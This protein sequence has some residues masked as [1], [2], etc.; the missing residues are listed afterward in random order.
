MIYRLKSGHVP[1]GVYLKRFGHRDDDK[2]WSCGGTVALTRE[3]LFRH[4]SRWKAQQMTLWKTE[5]QT[6]GWKAGNC[7]HVQISELFTTQECGHAV[8]DFLAASEIGRF[9]PNEGAVWS[10]L[11]AG[12]LGGGAGGN[13]IIL[14]FLSFFL[15]CPFCLSLT[16]HLSAGTKG[17]RGGAPPSSRLARR[18]R[19]YQGP[20]IL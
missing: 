14:F 10:G 15:S 17:S 11:R 16:F 3:H 5:V 6:T 12:R 8:M 9:R 2:C 1:T 4:C 7:R 18:R 20:V 19:G 13:G